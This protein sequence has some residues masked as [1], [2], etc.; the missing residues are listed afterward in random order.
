MR[1]RMRRKKNDLDLC[2]MKYMRRMIRLIRQFRVDFVFL[3]R[4]F[5]F[6]KLFHTMNFIQLRTDLYENCCNRN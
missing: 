2:V 4:E 1:M 6:S 3:S 5:C